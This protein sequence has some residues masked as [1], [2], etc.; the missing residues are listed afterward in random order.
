MKT[1]NCHFA[2]LSIH[3]LQDGR[4]WTYGQAWA[5]KKRFSR[6]PQELFCQPQ[7]LFR[8]LFARQKMQTLRTGTPRT[9]SRK[10]ALFHTPCHPDFD[11][12]RITKEK[13]KKTFSLFR[14][15]LAARFQQP[16]LRTFTKS[17][18]EK[19]KLFLAENGKKFGL[20]RFLI[21][22]PK[23]AKS[24]AIMLIKVKTPKKKT[25]ATDFSVSHSHPHT[26]RNAYFLPHQSPFHLSNFQNRKKLRTGKRKSPGQKHPPVG[27]LKRKA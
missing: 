14:T 13:K 25:A 5:G 10:Q 15:P 21:L 7:S 9:L 22:L 17:F 20:E 16:P 3:P 26:V 12:T 19:K 11:H 8:L 4:I 6:I 27:R 1:G 23:K 24:K 18:A 2:N